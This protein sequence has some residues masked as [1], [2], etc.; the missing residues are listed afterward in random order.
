MFKET[1]IN[2][3]IRYIGSSFRGFG[4]E[5][6]TPMRGVPNESDY[7]FK[8]YF[9]ESDAPIFTETSSFSAGGPKKFTINNVKI[10]IQ[11]GN[12]YDL[13]KIQ[14]AKDV[15]LVVTKL[16]N[17]KYN[18]MRGSQFS[19]L[20][21]KDLDN[22]RVPITINSS[23]MKDYDSENPFPNTLI[24]KF[25]FD[26]SGQPDLNKSYQM[27]FYLVLRKLRF[28][29]DEGKQRAEEEKR[30]STI[31]AAELLSYSQLKAKGVYNSRDEF[32]SDSGYLRDRI[33]IKFF[34]LTFRFS[35]FGINDLSQF[36]FNQREQGN[37]ELSD[38]S[39]I[40]QEQYNQSLEM[41][42]TQVFG[43][44]ALNGPVGGE[45]DSFIDDIFIRI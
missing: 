13:S 5:L 43:P 9:L 27:S 26:S 6:D 22:I 40:F 37:I 24:S 38:Y 35:Y 18:L 15:P 1:K 25:F 20:E 14:S 3:Q 8:K 29:E 7:P 21:K 16:R 34:D 17:G 45:D 10:A 2:K 31:T 12:I 42:T 23:I 41:K 4:V 32:V 19:T 44:K 11:K 33:L 39:E 36:A 28:F 30:F